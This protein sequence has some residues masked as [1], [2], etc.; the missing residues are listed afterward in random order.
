[1]ISVNPIGVKSDGS[2]QELV[3]NSGT[4]TTQKRRKLLSKLFVKINIK[5]KW[6][7]KRHSVICNKT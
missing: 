3:T 1:M 6:R 2:L 7:K 4:E 5:Q